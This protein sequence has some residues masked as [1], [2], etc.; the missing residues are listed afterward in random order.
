M[1]EQPPFETHSLT[2]LHRPQLFSLTKRDSSENIGEFQ[3]ID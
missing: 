3:L 2:T 1:N